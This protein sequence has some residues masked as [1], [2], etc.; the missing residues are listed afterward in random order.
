MGKRARIT[1]EKGTRTSRIQLERRRGTEW[2]RARRLRF[3]LS[4]QCEALFYRRR[5]HRAMQSLLLHLRHRVVSRA[6][7]KRCSRRPKEEWERTCEGLLTPIRTRRIVG[8][9]WSPPRCHHHHHH[10]QKRKAKRRNL[11]KTSF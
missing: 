4:D 9:E 11:A 7:V 2:R 10:H 5:Q 1:R 3:F 6:R 8:R